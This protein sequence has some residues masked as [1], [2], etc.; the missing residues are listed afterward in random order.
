MKLS[1]DDRQLIVEKCVGCEKVRRLIVKGVE[2]DYCDVYLYPESKWRN[3][4]V[5]QM[6]THLE[7]EEKVSPVKKIVGARKQKQKKK[8]RKR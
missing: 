7:I 3:K 5:C 4:K 2:G 6:A 8:V 1:L